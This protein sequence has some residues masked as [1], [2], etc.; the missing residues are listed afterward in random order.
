M[1]SGKEAFYEGVKVSWVFDAV[2]NQWIL[3]SSGSQLEQRR[4]SL[5]HRIE[6]VNLLLK[7]TG[8]LRTLAG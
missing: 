4:K 8:P 3:A 2:N 1:K 5:P 7:S 6:V